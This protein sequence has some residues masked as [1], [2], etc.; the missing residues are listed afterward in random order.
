MKKKEKSIFKNV[1]FVIGNRV[2]EKAK[3]GRVKKVYY[4]KNC[5]KGLMSQLKNLEKLG[6]ETE[7]YDGDSQSL[8]IA[9]GKPFPVSLVGIVGES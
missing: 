2:L 8:G 9:L 3:T 4:T 6:V 5:P 1:D 7:E